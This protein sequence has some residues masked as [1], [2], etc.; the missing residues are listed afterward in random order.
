MSQ[1]GIDK[2]LLKRLE[3]LRIV[4]RGV[5]GGN[6]TGERRSIYR[7]VGIEFADHR[8]YSPGDDFRYIDWNVLARTNELF[9]KLFDRQEAVPLYLLVDCSQSM[10]IGTPSKLQRAQEIATGLAHVG[11]CDGDLVQLALFNRTIVD[12]TRLLAH[13][14]DIGRVDDFLPQAQD[15]GGHTRLAEA[16]AHFAK[17]TSK[18]GIVFILSDFLDNDPG[19]TAT[20]ESGLPEGIREGLQTLL[21]RKFHVCGIH[22]ISA[23]EFAPA[24]TGE[25]SFFDSETGRVREVRVR[26][27]T[28]EKYR[29]AVAQHG[30]AV[31]RFLRSY[32]GDYVMVNTVVSLED[33]L[34]K[35]FRHAGIL[36]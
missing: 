15:A 32:G 10:H 6:P 26:K 33:T 34:T 28:L 23:E 25:F 36:Q 17:R 29:Q 5:F 19:R 2:S 22:L 12:Q 9:I 31:E 24:L 11:L 3:L 21:Y 14:R 20:D 18:R 35:L 30:H 13:R 27:G 16:L 7:G 8:P 1:L 4:A